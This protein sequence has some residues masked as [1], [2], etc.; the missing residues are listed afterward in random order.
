MRRLVVM[1]GAL[2]GLALMSSA[3][4]QDE[5]LIRGLEA[6]PGLWR[7]RGGSLA[8]SGASRDEP[9]RGPFETA[10]ELNLDGELVGEPLVMQQFAIV[11]QKLSPER[12]E[13]LLIRIEDGEILRRRLFKQDK[14]LHPALRRGSLVVQRETGGLELLRVGYNRFFVRTLTEGGSPIHDLL[15]DDALLYVRRGGNLE[16]WNVDAK[17][18]VWSDSTDARGRL[19]IRENRLFT[20]EYD[21]PGNAKLVVRDARTGRSRGIGD[22]G[23]HDGRRPGHTDEVSVH[24]GRELAVVRSALPIPLARGGDAYGAVMRTSRIGDSTAVGFVTLL[25]PVVDPVAWDGGFVATNRDEGKLWLERLRT[26][27]VVKFDG[28][29]VFPR[30]YSSQGAITRCGGIAYVGELVVDLALRRV[31][32]ALGVTPMGRVVPAGQHLLVRTGER[33]LTALVETGR[34]RPSPWVSEAATAAPVEKAQLVRTD[35]TLVDATVEIDKSSRVV[36][37]TTESEDIPPVWD[38]VDVAVLE[39]ES[40]TTLVGTDADGCIDAWTKLLGRRQLEEYVRLAVTA[41]VAKDLALLDRMIDAAYSRGAVASQMRRAETYQKKLRK[42]SSPKID[43]KRADRVRSELAEL[44][45]AEA[46]LVWDRFEKLPADAPEGV[47]LD[48]I[49]RQLVLDPLHPAARAEVRKRIPEDVPVAEPFAPLHWLDFVETLGEI[50]IEVMPPPKEDR[51]DITPVERTLGVLS[52]T[53]RPDIVGIRSEQLLVVTTLKSP[54]SIAR[55][56][57][58]GELI[59]AEL[60][61]MFEGGTNAREDRYPL[62]LLV[63][64]TQ[65][66]YLQALASR[67]GMPVNPFLVQS[68]GVYSPAEELARMFIPPGKDGFRSVTGTF[69]HELTH[70]WIEQRCPRFSTADLR[71]ASD[72]TGYWVVEGLAELM[73]AHE[74]DLRGRTMTHDPS[75]SGLDVTS[76]L[77]RGKRIPWFELFQLSIREVQTGEREKPIIIDSRF[78]LGMRYQVDRVNKFYAQSGAA[79]QFLFYG[80]NGRYRKQ[81]MDYAVAHYTGKAPA[82]GDAF[83]IS[84]EELGNK[85]A[86]WAR[87]QAQPE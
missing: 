63:Y 41:G 11:E 87:E 75:A 42:S 32:R 7:V 83:G 22:V 24:L 86:A 85:I 45:A 61:K 84:A 69:A 19:A 18:L 70:Q 40:G 71:S 28:A 26:D 78:V 13:L 54:G 79:A 17:E 6:E 53:W 20:V 36:K 66:E 31:I 56:V 12:R 47:R 5:D 2:L 21:R 37:V 44:Q 23:H 60:E 68:L 38:L 16:C 48:L 62:T 3:Q 74:F 81:L 82:I 29:R 33:K 43:V 65:E 52:H 55:L 30:L 73:Q 49:R 59:C 9:L 77:D 25:S 35:G 4:A 15:L 80:E 76:Q 50:R 34:I 46:A 10:W 39:D 27:G 67:P 58:L 64:E 72:P 14:P 8:R 57:S 51:P 1:L